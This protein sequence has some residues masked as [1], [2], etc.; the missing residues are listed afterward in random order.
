MKLTQ[1]S[2]GNFLAFLNCGTLHVQREKKKSTGK[3]LKAFQPAH[4]I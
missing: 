2:E 4:S 1:V 3:E